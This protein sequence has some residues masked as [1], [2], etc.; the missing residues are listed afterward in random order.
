MD[1]DS[2]SCR[3][4][5]IHKYNKIY[6]DKKYYIEQCDICGFYKVLFKTYNI[7]SKFK[8]DKLPNNLVGVLI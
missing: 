1:A 8:P 2:V 5:K 3:L 4:L 7:K 6:E